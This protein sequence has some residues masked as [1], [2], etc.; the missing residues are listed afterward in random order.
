MSTAEYLVCPYCGMNRV[1]QKLGTN[2]KRPLT[3]IKGRSRLNVVDP[4]TG[5]FIDIRD[6]SG[7]KGSGFK[8]ID[9]HTL[10]EVKN[11]PAYADLVKQLK[12]HSQL[13][14]DILS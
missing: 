11:D 3:T 1:L 8:R 6:I 12:E 7:G 9:F 4:H 10:V 2:A 14:L 13:I 5:P